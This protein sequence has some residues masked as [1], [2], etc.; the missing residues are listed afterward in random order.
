MVKKASRGCHVCMDKCDLMFKRRCP[1][2]KGD[3]V[4]MVTGGTIGWEVGEALELW[5][6]KDDL[7]VGGVYTVKRVVNVC[8]VIVTP[9]RVG[10]VHHPGHFTRLATV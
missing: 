4:Q 1:L 6:V 5:W 10:Y 3:T 9:S 2:K 8:G 7:A